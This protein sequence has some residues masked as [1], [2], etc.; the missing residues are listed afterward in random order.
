MA[1]TR[2]EALVICCTFITALALSIQGITLMLPAAKPAEA[3]SGAMMRSISRRS[4]ADSVLPTLTPYRSGPTTAASSSRVSP[5]SSELQRTITLRPDR[6]S[7]GT[8]SRTILRALAFSAGGTE[9]SRSHKTMSALKE[10][11]RSSMLA[12]LP[13]TIIRL[14]SSSN[15]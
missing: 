12:R 14:R 11:A 13:G 15:L 4:Q 10:R 9:S 3:S 7:C 8:H 2:G 1:I 6:R 5:V